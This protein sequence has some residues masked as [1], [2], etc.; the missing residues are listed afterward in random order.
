MSLHL[1]TTVMSLLPCDILN[2]RHTITVPMYVGM[3][4]LSIEIHCQKTRSIPPKEH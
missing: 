2:I 4:R 3:S 1:S